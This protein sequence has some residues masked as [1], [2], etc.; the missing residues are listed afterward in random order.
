MPQKAFTGSLTSSH[1]PNPSFPLNVTV[2]A[3]NQTQSSHVWHL[4]TSNA[5]NRLQGT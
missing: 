3:L 4:P 2:L 1:L 5:A